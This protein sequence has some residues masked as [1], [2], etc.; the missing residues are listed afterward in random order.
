MR[1]DFTGIVERRAVK[2]ALEPLAGGR[3]YK[4][5]MPAGEELERYPD[6]SPKPYLVLRTSP[7]IM[8]AV[9]RN[10]ASGEQGQ[11]H[12]LSGMIIA[13]AERDDDAED[14]AADAMRLTIG[15]QFT[16]N[17]SPLQARGGS[18]WPTAESNARPERFQHAFYWRCTINL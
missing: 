13:V 5:T 2:A 4:T 7:P 9:G 11:P 15:Q 18:A 8:K 10:V 17:S 14:L 16:E 3:V 6:G 1:G 12:F